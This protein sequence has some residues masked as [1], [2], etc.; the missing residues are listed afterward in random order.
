MKAV[1]GLVPYR[2]VYV[3]VITIEFNKILISDEV[4]DVV[5]NLD[6]ISD[7]EFCSGSFIPPFVLSINLRAR[8]AE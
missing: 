4:A 1:E 5:S 2:W 7:V 8:E 3:L 6:S